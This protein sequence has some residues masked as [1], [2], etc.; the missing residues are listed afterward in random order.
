MAV[1]TLQL[2]FY[3]SRESAQD[4]SCSLSIQPG[5]SSA[6]SLSPNF[7]RS[8]THAAAR[9]AIDNEPVEYRCAIEVDRNRIHGPIRVQA[10]FGINGILLR[11][12]G[13]A[14]YTYEKNQI[15]TLDSPP[16]WEALEG[17]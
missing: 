13:G 8:G 6:V 16:R 3:T 11:P 10:I 2:Y 17:P 4:I 1:E 12:G 14:E 15:L 9:L 7:C 5:P